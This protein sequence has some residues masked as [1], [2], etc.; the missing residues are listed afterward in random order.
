MRS[1]VTDKTVFKG[2][3]ALVTKENITDKWIDL[4]N[5]VMEKYKK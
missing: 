3:N 2:V 5:V 4:I 1:M